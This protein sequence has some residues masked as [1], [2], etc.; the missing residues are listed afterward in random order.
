M[1]SE[2]NAEKKKSRWIE[3]TKKIMVTLLA[4]FF[5]VVFL[6]GLGT[7]MVWLKFGD[8]VM[9]FVDQANQK[10]LMINNGTFNGHMETT[11]Y[12]HTGKVIQEL[13]D[14]EYEYVTKEKINPWINKAFIAIEDE[15]FYQHEGVDYKAIL[16]AAWVLIKNKGEITQGGSTITQ[17]LVKNVFL[18][19]EKTYM[20]K[21]EEI[22][23][24]FQLEKKFSKEDIMEFY[25][26]N[27]YFGNGNYGVET[28]A[29]HYFSK[30]SSELTLAE[31]A[32]LV[33]IPNNP[34]YYNPLKFENHTNQRKELILRK[35]R[36]LGYISNIEYEKA[37][38]EKI[39][40]KVKK[41]NGS[42]E[43]YVVNYA[44]S[45]ATKALMERK[46]FEFQYDFESDVQR[47]EYE[48]KYNSLYEEINKKIRSGGYRIYTTLDMEKQAIVQK[49]VDDELSKFTLIDIKTG[50]YQ[51]QGA[52]VVLDNK[53]AAVVAIVGGRSQEGVVDWFNRAYQAYRQPGSAIKPLI[54][55]TPAFERGFLGS[56]KV[57]DKPIKD[58]PLNAQR[59]YYGSVS[60]RFATE[61]SLNTIPFQLVQEY[62]AKTMLGYLKKMHFTK[63]VDADDHAGIGVGGFTYG[64]TPLE[65][66]GGFSTLARN[67]KY[68]EPSAIMKIVDHA[69]ETIYENKYVSTLVYDSGSAYVMTDILKGTLQQRRAS[70]YGL[71][72]P[73]MPTAGKTGTTNDSKDGWFAGYTPYYTAVTWVGNDQPTS[74]SKLYGATYPG[75]MWNDFMTEI[76]K[77]LKPI[78]FIVPSDVKERYVSYMGKVSDEPH[79]GWKK[80]WVPDIYLKMHDN[81]K[82][83][84]PVQTLSQNEKPIN[85]EGMLK[86]E[87]TK[88]LQTI[89]TKVKND[90]T[91][92]SV[93]FERSHSSGETYSS[94]ESNAPVE[95]SQA[96]EM[97]ERE[98]SFPR[99]EVGKQSD[100]QIIEEG[101]SQ[102][103]LSPV[104]KEDLDESN[105]MTERG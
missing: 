7:W 49:S 53:N 62:S 78:D 85:K 88:K 79:G 20:R 19:N 93:H 104:K 90:P 63:L 98:S 95:L 40:L 51:T 29:N 52:A 6:T 73:N 103:I 94:N 43:S 87:S 34:S 17:Q 58:G 36:E 2:Y 66:A 96:Q 42:I 1:K 35:M 105:S 21:A 5:S 68:I 86:K 14:H 4:T 76:H 33:A 61:L 27:I 72:V 26:N 3:K 100:E 89:D 39:K 97:E 11:I 22:L 60:I 80:E 70:G 65:M 15:R 54:A 25:V 10:V 12:D 18:T 91:G 64:V 75:H 74:I 30:S 82:R 38:E 102:P 46:G 69:N 92:K 99:I 44:I 45:S 24:A 71:G 83:G 84:E 67:G 28:A 41:R 31:V 37:L 9:A 55:Y 50:R 81:L 23:I 16:R 77:G 59:K 101:V 57:Q 56:T 8:D 13:A 47:K 32:Y 48:E